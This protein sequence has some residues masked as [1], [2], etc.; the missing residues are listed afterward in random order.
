[1]RARTL[2]CAT[3]GLAAV[4]TGSMLVGSA[5]AVVPAAPVTV[6]KSGL[7]NPRQMSVHNGSVYIA[8]AGSCRPLCSPGGCCG[9]TGSLSKWTYQGTFTR[10][11][12]GFLSFG[13]PDGT[14]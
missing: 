3:A 1:M 4:L 7:N 14:F 9:F 5:G 2:V 12:T 13:G 11:A 8:E 6:V 10:V